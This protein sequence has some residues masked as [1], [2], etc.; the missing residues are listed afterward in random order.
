MPLHPRLPVLAATA[1]LGLAGI[2]CAATLAD[3]VPTDAAPAMGTQATVDGTIA[4][5][6]T[7]PWT[8]DGNAVVMLRT[9]AGRQV[10]VQ[11]PAR[12]NLCKAAPVDV[13]SLNVGRRARVVGTVAAENV[14]VVC[15]RAG[16]RLVLAD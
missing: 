10:S 2:G 12:W 14:L 11:L 16:H 13:A 1:C 6:D 9:A 4:S 15:E 8:Y 7:Q 3:P 5:I